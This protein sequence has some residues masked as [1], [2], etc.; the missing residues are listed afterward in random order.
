[1]TVK[2]DRQKLFRLRA[3]GAGR[4]S[5]GI[6]AS[7]PA[8]DALGTLPGT[9]TGTGFNVIWR[10]RP[11]PADDHFLQ[12]N[13]T[14]ETL[15]FQS[16]GGL[17]PNRGLVQDDI[18]LTGLRYLQ[19]IHD[20]SGFVPP[21][22]GGALHIEPGFWL[23]VP[24]TTAP[25]AAASIV[26]LGS[27]PHG[28]AVLAAGSSFEVGGPPVIPPVRITPFQIGAP[29]KK[30]PF[31]AESTLTNPSIFRS[32]PLPPAI[33]Q[34]LVNN[35]NR[36]LTERLA[37]QTV[38]HTTTIT[39]ST[40]GPS[41][42]LENIA[43]LGQNADAVDLT[44]TFWIETVKEADGSEFL[45]LQYTQKLLLNFNGL[46]WPHVSVANLILTGA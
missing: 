26:R 4:I 29:K 44:A 13:L 6:A 45:Q 20:G 8:L 16:I 35:P 3:N 34:K 12:L 41:S 23:S 31:P 40:D 33:T 15:A 37:A 46:S 30:V 27:I 28:N 1:M 38:T 11:D 19:Q 14:Q 10:P 25:A 32:A 36:F 39:V 43:F 2:S 42:G 17:V 18:N 5:P 21:A 9:W 24:A 22:G 7:I